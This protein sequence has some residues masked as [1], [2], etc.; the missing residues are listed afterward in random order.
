MIL[1]LL[2]ACGEQTTNPEPLYMTKEF[3]DWSCSDYEDFS[4]IVVSTNTCEDH[5]TGLYWLIAE[6]HMVS[7]GGLKRKLNK[8]DNWNIDCLYQTELP[9]I[10]DYCIEVEGVTL[11]AYVEPATWSGALFG[12]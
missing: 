4:E 8:A 6:S 11:T 2:L 9:L 7:G 3:Y 12:D 5:E 1:G 10:D